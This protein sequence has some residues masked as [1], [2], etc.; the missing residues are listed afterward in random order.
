MKLHSLRIQG[1]RKHLDTTINFGASTFLIGQNNIGKSTVFKALEYLLTDVRKLD[2]SEEF[3][4]ILNE[5]LNENE[6]ITDKIILTAEF[7]NCP[8][9]ARTWKGLKGRVFTY[10]NTNFPNETGYRI[11]YRKTFVKGANVKIEMKQLQRN[12]KPRFAQC[13]TLDDYIQNGLA[14]ELINEEFPTLERSKN[15][16]P[17]QKSQILTLDELYDINEELEEW[18]LNPGGIPGNVLSRL[19][20]FLLIPAQDKIDELSGTSGALVKTLNNLFEE[21]R[22]ASLNFQEA[23]RH[24]ELLQQEL[25]PHDETKEFGRMM[26]QLNNILDGVFPNTK[27]LAAAS[28]TDANRSIRPVFEVKMS[29]NVHTKVEK[30]GT[31]VIRSAVFAM[32]RYRNMRENAQG[33]PPLIIGFE[34]PEI[35][36]HPNAAHQ[37]RDTIYELASTANNQ[38]VCTTHSPFMIDLGR[39]AEQVLNHF[40]IIP[41]TVTHRGD[42]FDIYKVKSNPFNIT[43]AYRNLTDEDKTFVKMIV[44]ID[45]HM[46]KIFFVDNVLI[47][48]GD[49]EDIVIRETLRRMPNEVR[50]DILHNWHVVKARG[51]A[52]IISLVKYFNAM[53]LHPFVIHDKDTGVTDAL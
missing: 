14:E 39:K 32:L 50:K 1:L 24:L 33:S 5:S 25:D 31:G 26:N 2:D 52:T 51:K 7:R 10:D 47:V 53:G 44:R 40:S 12:L 19:P 20:N 8:E 3:F 22:N 35:Y 29:S 46:A 9:E 30:Q 17:T 18:F 34:E 41:F 13:R 37:L 27:L 36:L 48:E 43:E 45:D 49:T 15:L 6:L 4:S 11:F 23:Q 21:V 28:L 16:T 38:I 42:E